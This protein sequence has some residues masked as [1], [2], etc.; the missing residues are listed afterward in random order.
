[1]KQANLSPLPENASVCVLSARRFGDAIINARLLKEAALVRPDI[2]WII[3]T[4]PEFK[5]LFELMGF[6]NIITAQLPIAGG[7]P[8]FIKGGWITLLKSI[9]H[10][11][12][13]NIDISI[14]FIG[15]TRE[16]L[17][18]ALTGSKKHCSPKWESGHWMRNLIWRTQIPSVQYTPISANDQWVYG[19]IPKFLS[20]VLD[21]P[22]GNRANTALINP[23]LNTSTKVAFHPYSSQCFKQWS[24]QNWIALSKLL[25]K[26]SITPVIICSSNEAK[27][28]HQQFS[29]SE[30]SLSIVECSSIDQLISAIKQIDI[31]IGVDSFLVHLASALGKKTI[32]IN[33]GNLPQ[34]WAPPNSQAIGQSGGCNYYPCFS[35]PKCLGTPNESACIKSISPEQILSAVEL[36]GNTQVGGQ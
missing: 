29:H 2:Q 25:N 22:I 36:S 8:K 4:K 30:Q 33:A 31:L 16:S 23:D 11:R 26:K 7:V 5:P 35:E 17:F 32:V 34:W 14:D 9:F 18:G 24:T 15:D 6:K 21:I 19:F 12:T 3:W 20:T 10:L 28:A 1:M 27:E 13:L